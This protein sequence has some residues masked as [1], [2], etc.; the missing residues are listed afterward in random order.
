MTHP[1][2]IALFDMDGTLCDYD[3]ALH[4]E[5]EKIRSPDELV[6]HSLHGVKDVP[7]YIWAR[8]D[9]ITSSEDWWA[10]LPRF[11]LGWDVLDVA[12]ELGY[13]AEILT[14][15]PRENPAALSGKL[16][17]LRNQK[18]DLGQIDFTMTRN[19]AGVYGR[20]LVDDFPNYIEPW[21][22]VRP[23]ARVIMPANSGN[24]GYTHER[25]VRYDGSNL[26]EVRDAMKEALHE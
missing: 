9:L 24:E 8:K 20:V 3:S 26:D 10:T 22:K 19:K 23:R 17:W 13:R 18:E 5:L 14:Q 11:Q 6:Y 4:R 16:I 25:L 1:D 21:L 15:G 7:D 12:I 2:N